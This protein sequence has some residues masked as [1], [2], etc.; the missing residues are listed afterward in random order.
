MPEKILIIGVEILE[1]LEFES[2]LSDDLRDHY[3]EILA[4]VRN[5]VEEFNRNTLIR[6][7]I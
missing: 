5:H 6:T 1:D 3:P 4:M 2:V 7:S